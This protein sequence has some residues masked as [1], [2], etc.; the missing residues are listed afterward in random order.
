MTLSDTGTDMEI[1]D[2]KDYRRTV[3]VLEARSKPPWLLRAVM[4]AL[5]RYRQARKMGWSR[6]QN[7]YGLTVFATYRIDPRKDTEVVAAAFDGALQEF[8]GE[9]TEADRGFLQ[10]L[11]TDPG[12]MGF[13]FVH[14]LV[15]DSRGFEGM[16]F[17]FGRRVAAEPRYRDRFDIIVERETTRGCPPAGPRLR[18]YIDPFRRP[19]E[20]F[21]ARVFKHVEGVSEAPMLLCKRA[22]EMHASW[23]LRPERAW[24]HWTSDYIDYFGPR[25]MAVSGTL[26]PTRADMGDR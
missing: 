6:A 21:P 7:K 12:L 10:E 2:E 24:S 26:F 18:A 8:A 5:E 1:R 17:S 9:L 16:T 19:I 13:A 14:D 22:V 20:A 4:N 3:R 11:R 15:E 23:S 25:M